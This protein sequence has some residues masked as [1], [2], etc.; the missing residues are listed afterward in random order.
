MLLLVD[1]EIKPSSRDGCELVG[2]PD[3][4]HCSPRN[5]DKNTETEKSKLM[6]D[7]ENPCDVVSFLRMLLCLVTVYHQ[8]FGY[9][10]LSRL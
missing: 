10:I 2:L 9:C 5:I 8:I 4:A 3:M 1:E 6:R 7:A